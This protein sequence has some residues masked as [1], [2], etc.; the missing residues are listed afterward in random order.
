MKTLALIHTSFIF[1]K[2]DPF[3]DS[4]LDEILPG[5]RRI[6]LLD[7]SLLA[8]AMRHNGVTPGVTRRFC[9]YAQ[10]AEAAGAD[11]ILSLCSSLGPAVDVARQLVSIPIIKIDDA[12]TEEAVS[13]ARRIGVLATV[14]STLTPTLE[15]VR[16]KA[17]QAGREVEVRPALA[18]GALEL[19]LAGQ[20]DQHDAR[21][22]ETARQAAPQV[23]LLLLA[24][25][26]MTRLASR[27]EQETGLHVLTSP[28]SGVMRARQA[29]GL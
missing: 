14:Q 28:R 4:L 6:N 20:R 26:S 27:L 5:V 13:S 9:A 18:Q 2:V 3:L 25:G 15:L 10:A 23:D 19:L 24:Q 22:V 16:S 17:A 29:L 7:D 21:V 11:A 1:I 8:E 12:M